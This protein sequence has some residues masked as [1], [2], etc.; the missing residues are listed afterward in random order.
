MSYAYAE[1]IFDVPIAMQGDCF[2]AR[3]KLRLVRNATKSWFNSFF[4]LSSL[5]FGS[6]KID[7]AKL[8]AISRLLWKNIWKP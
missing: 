5:P 8:F 2:R 4:F 3:F 1:M 6:Y 7:D